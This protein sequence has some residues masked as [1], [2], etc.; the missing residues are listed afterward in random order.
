M[1]KFT[2]IILAGMISALPLSA[3]A[4]DTKTAD[5]AA[6]ADEMGKGIKHGEYWR[7]MD[8]NGDGVISHDEFM[9][10]AEKRFKELD[11]NG[12]GKVTAEEMKIHHDKMKAQFQEKKA[13]REEMKAKEGSDKNAK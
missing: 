9:A 12:D 1:K 3:V 5:K 6:P 10:G 7:Q 8:T 11:I 4:A 2:K 13:M